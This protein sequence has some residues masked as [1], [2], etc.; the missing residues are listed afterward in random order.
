M[1]EHGGRLKENARRHGIAESEWLD[2]STGINPHSW[3]VPSIPDAIWQRLPEEEDGLADAARSYYGTNSLLPVAGSQAAIRALPSLI[4]ECEVAVLSPSFSEH[5]GSWKGHRVR[6]FPES[7]ILE[8]ADSARVVVVVNPNNPTGKV[9]R[10]KD[11]LCACD[12]LAKR[13]G[14]LIVD[15]AFMDAEPAESLAG[16]CPREGL[17]VLRS[18]GKFFGLAG[19]R[20]G[21]VLAPANFLERLSDSI[22]PWA[23]ANPSRFVTTLALQD[24]SWQKGMRE[25]LPGGARR[26]AGVLEDSGLPVSG[27]TALFQWT[28]TPNAAFIQEHLAKRGILVRLFA[29]P[30]S[31]RFGIPGDEAGFSRLAT[32]LEEF[33]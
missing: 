12:R 14:W 21:F 23:I 22:G 30:V 33:I 18:V 32:A 25:K 15:E 24:R 8:Q 29:E 20:T 9:F 10:R 16:D 2:L 1:P 7:A 19:A 28:K 13:G 17:V 3:Q 31:L 26:L 27:G 4:P 5:A 6:L 11:L